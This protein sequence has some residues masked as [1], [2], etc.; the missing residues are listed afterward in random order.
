MTDEIIE[1]KKEG[2][3][4]PELLTNDSIVDATEPE[5]EEPEVDSVP[6]TSGDQDYVNNLIIEGKTEEALKW[7]DSKGYEVA[8]LISNYKDT[9]KALN[10][11]ISFEE[12]SRNKNKIHDRIQEVI[13]EGQKKHDEQYFN[14]DK[15][16]FDDIHEPV[17]YQANSHQLLTMN[18]EEAMF[19]KVLQK[20]VLFVR[21]QDSSI[22]FSAKQSIVKWHLSSDVKNVKFFQPTLD[23]SQLEERQRFD[24]GYYE[25]KIRKRNVPTV[26]F[27][28]RPPI[29]FLNAF[30]KTYHRADQICNHLKSNNL[31][32]ICLLPSSKYEREEFDKLYCS[33]KTETKG[34]FEFWEIPYLRPFLEKHFDKDTATDLASKVLEMRVVEEDIYSDVQSIPITD[35]LSY[36]DSLKEKIQER[37]SH[38]KK[39]LE[40]LQECF[41]IG[42]YLQRVVLFTGA[43][44]PSVAWKEFDLLIGFFL[45][46]APSVPKARE[47]EGETTLPELSWT[48]KWKAKNVELMSNCLLKTMNKDEGRVIEF[49]QQTYG[50]HLKEFLLEDY[51]PFI[52][53]FLQQAS[54]SGFLFGNFSERMLRS[55]IQ[56]ILVATRND[57]NTYD[58][59][60]LK[61]IVVNIKANFEGLDTSGLSRDSHFSQVIELYQQFAVKLHYKQLSFSRL[62]DL[63]KELLTEKDTPILQNIVEKFVK[64]LVDSSDAKIDALDI[65]LQLYQHLKGTPN[66]NEDLVLNNIKRL[67]NEGNYEQKWDTYKALFQVLNIDELFDIMEAWRNI[68]KQTDLAPVEEYVCRFY[69]DYS[70][71]QLFN[72]EESQYGQDPP[73]LFSELIGNIEPS[74]TSQMVL[75]FDRLFD[76]RMDQVMTKFL[77]KQPEYLSPI[78]QVPIPL[79]NTAKP[80]DAKK[81]WAKLLANLI[82]GWTWVIYGFQEGRIK[83]TATNACLDNLLKQVFSRASKTQSKEI[84]AWWSQKTIGVYSEIIR[85][86]NN[87]NLK[88]K[89]KEQEKTGFVLRREHLRH[90]QKRAIKIH[91]TI[92]KS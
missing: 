49:T 28:E 1:N 19:K 73:T 70:M 87:S 12:Y 29:R 39:D 2:E 63:I 69:Y 54:N 90:M 66:F 43:F 35:S 77:V 68:D 81:A 52:E 25:K 50:Q 13:S 24:I 72:V 27:I 46:S 59:F 79:E 37:V 64:M 3:N 42:D 74:G 65:V 80:E 36:F 88:P 78:I 55:N 30:E 16:N 21:C 51:Y 33:I 34:L 10:Y 75:L 38:K 82:E 48:E 84:L 91:S 9:K 23:I 6:S 40:K 89:E 5:V 71:A 32:L 15:D 67:I 18:L 31:A 58:E 85:S 56:L 26:V 57:P 7:L 44:F 45:Q 62:T 14:S 61:N 53:P 22:L 41:E 47:K 86:I 60:W 92:H 76:N 4:S 8:S 11:T 20:R 17:L 83:S